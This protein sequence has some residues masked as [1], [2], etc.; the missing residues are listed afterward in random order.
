[1]HFTG[2]KRIILIIAASVTLA[3]LIIL[4]S[5]IRKRPTV[6]QIE[7]LIDTIIVDNS[8]VKQIIR[9]YAD[10]LQFEFDSSIAVGAAVTIVH[11]GRI[12]FTKT[13]GVKK[14]DTTTPVDIHTVFRLA[15]VSKGFAG[16]LACLLEQDSLISLDDKI[17]D[18]L[19]GF[20]LKNAENT[21][22][23]TIKQTLSHT[24]GLISHAYDNL[25]E[26]RTPFPLILNELSQ[27]NISASPGQLYN[28]QN[29]IFCLIDTI[30]HLETGMSY[31]E[32]LEKKIF[33]PLKMHDA[34][35][36]PDVFTQDKSNIAYPHI[37]RGKHYVSLAPNFG[38]YDLLAAA[39]VNASISDMSKWL[40]ALLGRKHHII[41]KDVL[42]N[43]ET[44]V[45]ETHL[46]RY[47]TQYWDHIESKYYSLGWRIYIYK[48]RKIIYHGGYVK[49]YRAEVAFCPEENIGIAFLENSSND[50]ASKS[51]PMFF[52]LWFAAID[53]N[54]LNGKTVYCH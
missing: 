32:L 14:A 10:T 25:A 39:G 33:R 50:L 41:N 6:K 5:S 7:K 12:L 26:V 16:V 46:K 37:L 15:S 8:P 2:K 11:D 21:E 1:M 20:R 3:L 28:Y 13:Y 9:H 51:V 17:I 38:Y 40:L 4:V 29:A 53:T 35:V 43:I 23:L 24:S 19:P 49:G 30:A 18:Y 27:V 22:N 44:P 45:I 47:Y 31:K 34:S 42:E 54:L 52:N 48:G 36:G